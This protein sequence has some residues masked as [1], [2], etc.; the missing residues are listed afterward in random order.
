MNDS[1]QAPMS[2]LRVVD[3]TM[4]WAG[5]ALTQMLADH[6]AD[7]IKIES[8]TRTDWWRTS[9]A[10]FVD[11]PED[12]DQAWEW[13]P[14]FNA[15]NEN[16]R[17][18][19]LD[20]DHPRGRELAR[21]LIARADLVVENFTPRVMKNFGFDYAGLTAENPRLIM[22]SMPAFGAEGP[23]ANFKATAFATESVAGIAAL[24]GD[25]GEP[26]LP[27]TAFADPNAGVVGALSVAMALRYRRL[28]GRGQ[29]IEVAQIEALTPFI[30]AALLK[31]QLTGAEPPRRGNRSATAAP[32]GVYPGLG[33][34]QWIAISVENDEQWDQLAR[35]AGLGHDETTRWAT[36][37]RRIADQD[38]LDA[39]VSAFTLH[40]SPASLARE[41]QSRG[42]P[43][44][45]VQ[46][47]AQVLDDP[48][49]NARGFFRMVDRAVVGTFP[50]PGPPVRLSLT[51]PRRN[52][53]APTLGE[54][55]EEV[56]INELGLTDDDVRRLEAD[57]VIG[58][59]PRFRR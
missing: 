1:S 55:N 13:S 52:R 39:R 56:L 46:D 5:P 20:L 37:E 48:H 33:E 15:V 36:R 47:A 8:C 2:G 26:M 29:H 14:L 4:G 45:A 17:G 40:H 7:V 51:P 32:Q 34:D 23:W 43:A 42:I 21:A 30:G 11:G 38:A 27:S 58:T 18:I 22:V 54:H 59:A 24:A 9:R 12:L 25:P 31:T 44:G 53:P 57:G 28:T 19:T 35:L 50:Y 49:L 10:L 41:L 6:G 16:K 3:F